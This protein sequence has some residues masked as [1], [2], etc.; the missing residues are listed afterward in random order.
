MIKNLRN[1]YAVC[2]IQSVF[3]SMGYSFFTEGDY[4]VNI[5]GVRSPQLE[6]NKFDD[7][8]ICAYKKLGVWRLKE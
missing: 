2:Y 8:M 7:T 6:A 5:I 4:N 3:E 1:E